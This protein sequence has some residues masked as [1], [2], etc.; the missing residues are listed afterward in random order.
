MSNTVLLVAGSD[1]ASPSGW[2]Q[3]TRISIGRPLPDLL[4][5]RLSYGFFGL[6]LWYPRNTASVVSTQHCGKFDIQSALPVDSA[7]VSALL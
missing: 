4:D 3:A 1:S 7:T 6:R 2:V 5:Q